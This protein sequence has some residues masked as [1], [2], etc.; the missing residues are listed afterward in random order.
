MRRIPPLALVVSLVVLLGLCPT[1][2]IAP[3]TGDLSAVVWVPLAPLSHAA[4]TVRLWL[5]PRPAA[6]TGDDATAAVER[7]YYRGLWHA[8]RIQTEA[9]EK[10]LSLYERTIGPPSSGGA[11]RLASATVIGRIAG[12]GG[13]AL[14]VNVGS[15]HGVTA[16]DVAVIDGDA[17]VGRLAPEVAAVSSLV[18]S[19]ADRSIG[20]FD[21][22]ITPAAQERSHRPSALAVQLLPDGSGSLRADVDLSAAVSVGDAVRLKDASWPPGAQ[23]MR[24]GRVTEVRRKD[25]QPLRGEVVVQPTTDPALIGEVV[26]KLSAEKRP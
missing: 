18:I 26:I 22:Y 10:K 12:S 8:E 3:L 4:T 20:R 15:Q 6:T 13:V 25:A 17:L 9:L 14:R 11:V 24:V 7:D 1:R 21:G 19:I 23:G 5:R 16:G 2:W